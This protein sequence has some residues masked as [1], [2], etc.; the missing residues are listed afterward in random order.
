[1]T[2]HPNNIGG[3]M[4][5][6]QQFVD[7]QNEIMEVLDGKD[8]SVAI[9]VLLNIVMGAFIAQKEPIDNVLNYVNSGIF[10]AYQNIE[11]RKAVH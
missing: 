8:M 2:T 9:P 10:F 7:Y 11:D 4:D 3:F 1:M 6:S 5:E